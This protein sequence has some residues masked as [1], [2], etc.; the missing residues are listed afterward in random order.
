MAGWRCKSK[1]LYL[2]IF[3]REPLVRRSIAVFLLFAVTSFANA[4]PDQLI[5]QFTHDFTK[6]AN[7]PV[8]T[9]TKSGAKWRVFLHGA[10]KTV[11]AKEASESERKEF[12]EQMWWPAEK[13][14]GAHCL[15]LGGEWQGLLCYA[16]GREGTETPVIA[17]KSDYFYFD[18]MGGL[19]EIRP[20]KK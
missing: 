3:K 13:A 16:P 14:I 8:Y 2:H 7:A 5:G 1:P 11:S 15:R 18:S 10:N 4:K 19:M 20:K 17:K 9:V 12:W 6:P